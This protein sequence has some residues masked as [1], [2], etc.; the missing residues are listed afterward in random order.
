MEIIVRSPK[1]DTEWEAYYALR[2]RI[3]REPLG[4][5][6]GSE[7]NEDDATGKHFAL[8]A[9]DNLLAIARLDKVDETT[10]QARFVAVDDKLQGQGL[11]KKIM[12]ALE[13]DA[14]QSGYTKIILH[15]RDYAVE[16]YKHLNYNLIDPSYKLFGVLQHYLME[17][18]L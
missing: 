16:F 15:A 4:Q 8:F 7:R 1:N 18:E 3:L 14:K 17:K 10:C 6:P 9:A 11:G 12:L 2:Y 13:N 5:A